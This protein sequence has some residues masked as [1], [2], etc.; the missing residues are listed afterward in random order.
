MAS[1]LKILLVAT[2]PIQ[3]DG[4]S[5]VLM[6]IFRNLDR[7][8][9][10]AD[11]VAGAGAEVCYKNEIIA[12]GNKLYELPYRAKNPLKYVYVLAKI[13]ARGQY[14]IV[15]V[16]GNSATMFFDIFAAKIGGA[17][18]RIPHSHNSATQHVILHYLLKPLLNW[19]ATDEIACSDIAGKWIFT[20][21]FILFK[22][23]IDAEEY[24]FNCNVRNQYR[25][26]LKLENQFV[27]GH[28]GR[29]SYQKNH[30]FLIAVF[31][32]LLKLHP[33]STLLLIGDGVMRNY[34]VSQTS[35]IKDHI[36]FLGNRDDVNNLYQ[37]MDVFVLPSRFEGLPIVGIEAQASGLKLVLSN[38]I[39]QQVNIT[40]NVT[41]LP[42]ASGATEWAKTILQLNYQY[43]REKVYENSIKSDYD[44][45]V[46]I[47]RLQGIYIK[48]VK[49]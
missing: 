22:N 13:V 8:V 12:R 16:H 32:E 34:I 24:K 20:K 47:Q 39:T 35:D 28:V 33:K 21:P 31:R 6:E 5:K 23:G 49:E 17:K 42:L 18:I 27:I 7:K 29:F 19:T 15:H 11:V 41:F 37:A 48:R 44:I 3:H 38:S 25:A 1:R 40:G 45:K 4:L 36:R 10:S 2:T 9:F 14:K 26:D 30:E 43:E 46:Q